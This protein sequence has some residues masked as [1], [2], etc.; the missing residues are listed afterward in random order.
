MH[1]RSFINALM[2]M[3]MMTMIRVDIILAVTTNAVGIAACEWL[4]CGATLWWWKINIKLL[5]RGTYKRG[6]I[7]LYQVL[8]DFNILLF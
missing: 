7:L 1:T 6:S 4:A 2:M 5:R 8:T 3:M